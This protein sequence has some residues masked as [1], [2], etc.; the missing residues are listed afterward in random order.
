MKTKKYTINDG[1]YK[2]SGKNDECYT[3]R[4]VVQSILR[5]IPKDVKTIWCP[6]DKEESNFVKV[7]TEN[8]Y[9]VI[10]SHIDDGKDFYS[11]EPERDYDIIISNPPFTN[12]K[13]I[14]ERVLSF[15]KPFMLLM[16]AQ[17]LNDAAPIDL[18]FKYGWDIQLIHFRNRVKYLNCGDK[19]PFKSLFFCGNVDG[20][21]GNE[22]INI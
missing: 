13:G 10:M 8:G 6:F 16:T 17:W 15:G 14:F 1:M 5:F 9:D 11:Y 7:L 3:P 20:M 22:Y 21:N 19:I 4:Y 18:H 2:T 12:K